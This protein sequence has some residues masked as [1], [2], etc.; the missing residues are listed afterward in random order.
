MNDSNISVVLSSSFPK[1][2]FEVEFQRN[3]PPHSMKTIST[4]TL[5]STQTNNLNST[6]GSTLGSTLSPILDATAK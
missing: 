1:A 6:L 3:T 5:K 4:S 2:L